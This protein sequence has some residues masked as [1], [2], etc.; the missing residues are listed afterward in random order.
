MRERGDTLLAA[1]GEK[2]RELRGRKGL[3][4]RQAARALGISHTRLTAFEAGRTISTGKPAVPRRDLLAKMAVLY[5]YPVETLLALAGYPPE[6][7]P[8]PPPG[9][10]ATQAEEIAHILYRLSDH[11]R[12]ILLGTARL[13]LAEH[14]EGPPYGEQDQ[15]RM[16]PPRG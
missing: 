13:L 9:E 10:V 16:G 15:E 2:L 7:V 11:E 8:P 1:L 12:K 6:D 14:I 4:L 3:G 5:D